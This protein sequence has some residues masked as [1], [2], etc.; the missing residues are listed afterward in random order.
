MHKQ[1][2]AIATLVLKDILKEFPQDPRAHAARFLKDPRIADRVANFSR[3]DNHTE[4]DLLDRD[5]RIYSTKVVA[6][7][8]HGA[9]TRRQDEQR[10]QNLC[11]ENYTIEP[12]PN[13]YWRKMFSINARRSIHVLIFQ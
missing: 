4:S 6:V 5:A 1:V 12:P 13:P 7:D 8:G 9:G 11:N 2:E 10:K 3:S